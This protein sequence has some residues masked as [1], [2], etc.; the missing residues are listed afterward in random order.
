MQGH[1]LDTPLIDACERDHAMTSRVLRALEELSTVKANHA[2]I[3][4]HA[5]SRSSIIIFALLCACC[6]GPAASLW[7][8]A[9]QPHSPEDDGLFADLLYQADFRSC[10]PTFLTPFPPWHLFHEMAT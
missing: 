4:L 5:H 1:Q 8:I 10:K 2:A 9:V 7:F 3:L 6:H